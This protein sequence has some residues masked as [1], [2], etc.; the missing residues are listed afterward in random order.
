[1]DLKLDRVIK[2]IK[3]KNQKKN[4]YIFLKTILN[5]KCTIP[6]RQYSSSKFFTVELSCS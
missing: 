2:N 1:M 5:I 3:A 4:I 6:S